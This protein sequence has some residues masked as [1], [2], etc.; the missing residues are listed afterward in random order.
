VSKSKLDPKLSV[1]NRLRYLEDQM[2]ATAALV[3]A[4]RKALDSLPAKIKSV[5][6]PDIKT[7]LNRL[8]KVLDQ[9]EGHSN[10][11]VRE[12]ETYFPIS[13]CVLNSL[14]YSFSAEL[15]EQRI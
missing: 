8:T 3:S 2:R 1:N 13:Y 14:L 10:Q 4:H 7:Q 11:K 9:L 15:I 6:P 5:V 12:G